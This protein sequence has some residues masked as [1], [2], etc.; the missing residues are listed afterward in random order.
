MKK[1]F[2]LFT[3][4]AAI[5]LATACSPEVDD[6]FDKSSSQRISEAIN[7]TKDI[8]TTPA[9][10]WVMHYYGSPMYGGYNVLCKFDKNDRVT[11]ASEV[12][13][14]DST[15]TSH[16]K[17]EQSQGVILSFDEYNDIFHYFSDPHNPD[18]NGVDGKG[19]L[20]DLEFRVMKASADSIILKGKKHNSRVVM[21]PLKKSTNWSNYIDAVQKRFASMKYNIYEVVIKGK[22]YRALRSHHT[23]SFTNPDSQDETRLNFVVTAK[24]IKLYNPVTIAGE[25]FSEFI[26]SDDDKWVDANNKNVV[27]KPV[28][29][30]I[31]EQFVSA[32][33]YFAFSNF[34]AYGQRFWNMIK[35]GAASMGENIISAG[36]GTEL[37]NK[38]KGPQFGLTFA[39]KG[40]EGTFWCQYYFTYKI[41][42]KDQI[43]IG[44]EGKGNGN[45]MYYAKNAGYLPC[46][47][48]FVNNVNKK[49]VDR[50]FT[51]ETDNLKNP[52]YIKFTE[53]DNSENTFTVTRNKVEDFFAN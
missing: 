47:L 25:T 52:T 29:P 26:Y 39:S 12:A 13:G 45:A 28:V 30:P 48:P 38:N 9:D 23:I 5:L 34:S 19:M 51:L 17:I 33:W 10:G 6:L 42:G 49:F 22:S 4:L 36:L 7:N 14:K 1:I 50:V 21:L 8:L 46:V 31:T 16:Y 2:N 27:L 41:I 20:G 35:P 37:I 32:N 18:K 24:G 53:V 40:G 11:V 15:F 44:F 43:S 3:F